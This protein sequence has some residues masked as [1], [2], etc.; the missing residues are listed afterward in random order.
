MKK[1]G[2]LFIFLFVFLFFLQ[3]YFI[4]AQG[5]EEG[6]EGIGEQLEEGIGKAEDIKEDIEQKRWD[7]LGEEW[8]KILLENR[9]VSAMDSFLKKIDIVFVVLF[10]EHYSLSLVLL[11]IILLWFYL[12]L[13][14]SEI[15]TDYSSFSSTTSMVI[16]FVLTIILA[17]FKILRAI[18]EFFAWLIFWKESN[19]WRF[20]IL[21]IIVVGMIGIYYLSSYMGEIHKKKKEEEEKQQEK[22]DR[23]F[24]RKIA[25]MFSKAFGKKENQ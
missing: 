20:V 23:H 4:K 16:G 15:L 17:Q 1:A 3:I 2:F 12:F 19:V 9:F 25:E 6:L 24:L 18:I 21:F 10:G 13:K 11:S 8:K 14:M 5:L 22:I 7:Y